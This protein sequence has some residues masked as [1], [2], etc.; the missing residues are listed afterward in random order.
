MK[1]DHRS[2][3]C[4]SSYVYRTEAVLMLWGMLVAVTNI[5]SV[6]SCNHADCTSTSRLDVISSRND[7]KPTLYLLSL[8]P[9]PID[10]LNFQTTQ[11]QPVW[12]EGPSV[13]LAGELA[14]DIINEHSDLNILDDYTLRLL[15]GDGGCNIIPQTSV[16][17]N[18]HLFHSGKHAL[19]I[20]GPGCSPSGLFVSNIIS[21]DE[22]GISLLTLHLGGS[23]LFTERQNFPYSFSMLDTTETVANA[24]IALMKRN[25]WNKVIVLYD[26]SQLFFT[27]LLEF[28]EESLGADTSIP[29][30]SLIFENYI[31]FNE[32]RESQQ[33]IILLLV[34]E[35]L[36]SRILCIAFT[37][38]FTYPTY[39]WMLVTSVSEDDLVSVDTTYEGRPV[40]CTRKELLDQANNTIFFQYHF[41]TLDADDENPT[42]SGLS[43]KEFTRRYRSKIDD[44]NSRTG[45]NL[46]ESFWAAV[47]FDTAWAMAL[48]INDSIK[49]L[50]KQNLELANFRYG[51]NQFTDTFRKQL[52]ELE[53]EGVSG[54]ISFNNNTGFVSRGI[55]V[56]QLQAGDRGLKRILYYNASGL[57]PVSTTQLMTIEDNF[58]NFGRLSEVPVWVS[59][60]LL[61]FSLLLLTVLAGLQ[62]ISI[63]HR[64]SPSVKASSLKILHLAYVGCYLTIIGIMFESIATFLSSHRFVKCEIE[65][66]ALS[67][68]FC[69]MTLIFST[70]CVRTWRLY[71]IFVHF[72]NPGMFISDKALFVLVCLCLL[73]EFPAILAWGLIDPIKPNIVR[74]FSLQLRQVYC[75]NQSFNIWFTSLLGYNALLLLVSCYF[76]LRCNMISQKDFKTNS[77]LILAYLLTIE[78]T[79]GIS[80]YLLHPRTY[81]PLPEFAAKT[82]TFLLY[83]VS[84][85]VFL[86]MPPILPLVRLKLNEGQKYRKQMS[87][88]SL[89]GLIHH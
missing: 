56:K 36:L 70:I 78:L 76:A 88:L 59:V 47:Y 83:V 53:F 58:D 30:S 54:V 35:N 79:T 31:P 75:T 1:E 81:D 15:Q 60:L 89:K 85:C 87:S 57:V 42:H 52:L 2:S 25:M 68:L 39:Q 40:S 22:R 18:N 7:T 71:R 55:D 20:I 61:I 3:I 73:L 84:C 24:I 64:K 45:S 72:K 82:V 38:G 37:N 16:A 21:T 80:I 51:Q 27:T 17:L 69:G 8:L 14:V 77:I 12:S 32:I 34:G 67:L 50:R 28:F 74:N 4:G 46:Q 62:C 23:P 29:V 65:Q 49:E 10:T 44:H 86:F 66:V 9:Y 43:Y 11:T 6:Q 33:R 5:A 48:A 41:E 13:Y 26:E 19:G 63:A